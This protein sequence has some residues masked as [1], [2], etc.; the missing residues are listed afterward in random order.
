MRSTAKLGLE[1][2]HRDVRRDAGPNAQR[3]DEQVPGAH[4]ETGIGGRAVDTPDVAL[5]FARQLLAARRRRARLLDGLTFGEPDWDILLDAFVA[6]GDRQ[7]L[8]VSSLCIVSHISVSTALRHI[9]AMI[10]SGYLQR[11][12]DRIDQRRS[13]IKITEAGEEKLRRCLRDI[14]ARVVADR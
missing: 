8:P 12:R 14:M 11:S 5:N 6:A 3:P 9:N 2:I 4:C 1:S 7:V 10:I 13:L